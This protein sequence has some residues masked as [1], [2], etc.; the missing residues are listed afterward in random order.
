MTNPN[1]T[2]DSDVIVF[3]E[4]STVR[5]EPASTSVWKLLV[6]DDAPE[7]HDISRLALQGLRIDNH[8]VALISVHSATAA[9]VA[10]QTHSDIAVI[11]LD[12]VMESDHAGLDLVRWIRNDLGNTRVRIVLRTGQPGHAPEP[13]VMLDYDINDYRD[14]TELTAQRL[15]TTVIGAVRAYRD[16]STIE[17]Q[18]AGLEQVVRASA[19]LFESQSGEQFITGVLRQLSALISPQDSAMFFQGHELGLEITTTALTVVAGTGRFAAFVRKPVIQVVDEDVWSDIMLLL[20]T[21]RPVLR[22][23]YNLFA[24]FRDEEMWAAVFLEGLGE[25]S[26]WDQRLVELFCQNAA[27]A[28]ENLRLHRRQT[29]LTTAFARFVPKQLLELLG[30]EDATQA[31][32]GDQIQREM[33]VVFVDLRA[34]TTRA[35]VQSP[36]ATFEFLNNFFA[37]IVP[38]IHN[39]GG[40]VDKYL[41]DGLMALFPDDPANAVKAALGV[42]ARSREFGDGV[43]V[44]VHRGPVILGLVGAAGRMESTVVSDAVNIAARIERLTRRFNADLLISAAVVLDLPEALQAETRPL[45]DYV[46]PGRRLPVE[47]YEVFAGDVETS[48]AAKQRGRNA[49]SAAVTTMMTGH[50]E[51]AAAAFSTLATAEPDDRVLP[52]LLDECHRRGGQAV[53]STTRQ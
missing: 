43:G 52:A 3:A 2:V 45:G 23:N 35:E 16:L 14:K 20:R 26:A 18:K 37:V 21:R 27:V 17:A 49:V 11:L 47:V 22:R 1:S 38:E 44:G 19:A 41:G 12:V 8:P 28:L 46:V 25:L 31:G 39:C 5:P 9:R 13:R 51:E 40:V 24:I 30:R 53:A 34:F 33:T 42:V 4:D 50:L 15:T 48:R 10:L 36:A 6:V 32:L 7:V 29:A